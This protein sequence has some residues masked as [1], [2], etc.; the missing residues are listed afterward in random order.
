MTDESNTAHLRSRAMAFPSIERKV[1]MPRT[2]HVRA[3]AEGLP[4]NRRLALIG[5]LTAATAA[6]PYA[7][8]ADAAESEIIRLF[9]EW[10]ATYNSVGDLPQFEDAEAD[11]EAVDARMYICRDIEE[12]MLA[13]PST[14][15]RDFAAK[16]IVVTGF[17]D[18]G[19]D[20]PSLLAEGLAFVTGGAS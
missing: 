3:A 12:R 18:F 15:A 2:H 19:I 11:N 10:E 20:D 17:G 14:D 16:V 7:R 9:R 13:L 1:T 6:A 8:P 4:I 5:G